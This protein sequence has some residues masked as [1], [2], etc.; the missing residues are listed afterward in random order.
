MDVMWHWATSFTF[1]FLFIFCFRCT[2]QDEFPKA[3]LSRDRFYKHWGSRNVQQFAQY[4]HD[5]SIQP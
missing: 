4:S 1:F 3:F 2:G 5:I